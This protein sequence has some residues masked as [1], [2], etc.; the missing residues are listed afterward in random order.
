MVVFNS[1]RTA[2]SWASCFTPAALPPMSPTL[3][4]APTFCPL[5]ICSDF[6]VSSTLAAASAASASLARLVSLLTVCFRRVLASSHM[7]RSVSSLVAASIAERSALEARSAAL[8]SRSIPSSSSACTCPLVFWRRST[9]ASSNARISPSF[10]L[11]RWIFSS[12]AWHRS[13]A[14]CRSESTRAASSTI[15]LAMSPRSCARLSAAL[16]AA[17]TACSLASAAAALVVAAL[18]RAITACSSCWLPS[19]RTDM[20]SASCA[21]AATPASNA[22]RN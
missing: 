13:N 2:A 3:L 19:S 1:P 9:L 10:L 14:S 5:L 12:S 21:C 16:R 4:L 18:A 20:A 7:R 11:S 8:R 6:S 15:S 22:P 17:C